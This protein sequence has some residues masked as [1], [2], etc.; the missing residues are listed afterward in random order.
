MV[1][2]AFVGESARKRGIG[3][4]FHLIAVDQP[5]RVVR[6]SRNSLRVQDLLR[7]DSILQGR[8]SVEHLM[9][10]RPVG[11]QIILAN[12]SVPKDQDSLGELCDVV[13]VRHENNR[14][15]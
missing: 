5:P 3:G 1:G 6:R 11:G 7:S 14:Q 4:P 9:C 2:Y 10:Q 12:L 15:S 13:F 8:Q